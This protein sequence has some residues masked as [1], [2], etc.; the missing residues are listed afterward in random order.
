MGDWTNDD[1]N[2]E[3]TCEML[4]EYILQCTF[5]GVDPGGDEIVV[6]QYTRYDT[7]EDAYTT[8]RFV[9]NGYADTGLTW[10]D[11]DTWTFVYDGPDGVRFRDTS[12]VSG[13]A[14]TTV[15]HISEQGGDWQE[16]EDLGG[17]L[18]RN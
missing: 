11:G 16:M 5:A 6:V 17:S 1:G 8:H 12:T 2:G 13:N 4:G 9:S 15:W 18:T 10:V 3:L 14:M 7:D